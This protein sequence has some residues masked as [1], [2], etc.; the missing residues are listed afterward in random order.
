MSKILF[1]LFAL[2]CL[3][4]VSLSFSSFT[5]DFNANFRNLVHHAQINHRFR[6][7]H[8][9]ANYTQKEQAFLNGFNN[10]LT[11]F[12]MKDKE[13]MATLMSG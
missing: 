8:L 10:K 5:H 7:N 9:D 6:V 1:V 12:M 4:A 2:S 13:I 11:G 3:L